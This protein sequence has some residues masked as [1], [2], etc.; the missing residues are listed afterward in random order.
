MACGDYG[1]QWLQAIAGD[2]MHIRDLILCGY[3]SQVGGPFFAAVVLLGMI[4]LPVYIRTQSA[5]LPTVIT[6]IVGG[7]LLV[8]VASVAQAIIVVMLLFA[9]GLAPVLLLRRIQR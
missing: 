1:G 6:L 3:Q 7:V 5:L 9:I 4:N 2:G 8:E